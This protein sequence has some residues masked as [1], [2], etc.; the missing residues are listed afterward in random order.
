VR[1]PVVL[2]FIEKVVLKRSQ[3]ETAVRLVV[4]PAVLHAEKNIS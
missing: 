1:L 4:D 3:S 2:L